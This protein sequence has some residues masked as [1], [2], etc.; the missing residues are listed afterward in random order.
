ME[1]GEHKKGAADNVVPK[2]TTE[3][4]SAIWELGGHPWSWRELLYCREGGGRNPT[5]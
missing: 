2:T 1:T 5:S 4:N 3:E